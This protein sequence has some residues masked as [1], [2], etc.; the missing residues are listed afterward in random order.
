MTNNKQTNAAGEL[1]R[2]Q[3]IAGAAAVAA[4]A[5]LPIADPLRDVVFENL[6]A[7]VEN[8]CDFEG[9]PAED[10]AG[11]MI[12]YAEDVADRLAAELVPHVEEWL[13]RRAAENVWGGP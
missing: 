12:A 1:S 6:A 13:R 9:W 7:A 5:A 2:R 3:A 4:A 10:I 11:D 8:G